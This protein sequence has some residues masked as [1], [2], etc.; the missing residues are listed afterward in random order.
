MVRKYVLN[1]LKADE[2]CRATGGANSSSGFMLLD[3]TMIPLEGP[4]VSIDE[5]ESLQRHSIKN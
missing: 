1:V 2:R 4:S 3:Q 5:A